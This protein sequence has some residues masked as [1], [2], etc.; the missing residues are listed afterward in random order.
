MCFVNTGWW[1]WGQEIACFKLGE[2]LSSGLGRLKAAMAEA[3]KELLDPI[4]EL[5][6]ENDL[7]LVIGAERK[8]DEDVDIE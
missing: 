7:D 6:I 5:D 4:T 1:G 3:A 8:E 2:P